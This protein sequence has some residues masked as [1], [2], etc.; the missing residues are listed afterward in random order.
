MAS[1]QGRGGGHELAGDDSDEAGDGLDC[2]DGGLASDGTSS[3]STISWQFYARKRPSGSEC[4]CSGAR[5]RE[6]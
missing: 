2:G 4:V 5:K 1:V 3:S 6:R